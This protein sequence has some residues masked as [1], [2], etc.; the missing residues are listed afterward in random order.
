MKKALVTVDFQKDFVDGALGFDGAA[1]LDEKIAARIKQA[2]EDGT[3]LLFTLDT[4]SEN[5]LETAEGK[6]LPVKHCIKGTD[7]WRLYGKT[8]AFLPEAAAVFE[9]SAFGSPELAEFLKKQDYSE[10]EFVG[11]VSNI[12]VISNAVLAK[13]ALPEAKIVVNAPLTAS[14]DKDLHQKALDVMAGM[15]IEIV[16]GGKTDE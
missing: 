9:K 4:H 1:A 16:S 11:L 2:L 12:C 13:S 5:Y 7:G 15:Q 3:D 10:V 14:F 8:A 6:K